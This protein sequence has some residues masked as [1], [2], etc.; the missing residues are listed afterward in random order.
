MKNSSEEVSL[1]TLDK[2]KER[3]Q[4]P[5]RQ[6][7]AQKEN[8]QKFFIE[9]FQM[10]IYRRYRWICTFKIPGASLMGGSGGLL[11]LTRT[12]KKGEKYIPIPEIDT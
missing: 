11:G 3:N 4:I 7:Y 6:A 8:V 1:G 9:C 10:V 5:R 2:E 12:S